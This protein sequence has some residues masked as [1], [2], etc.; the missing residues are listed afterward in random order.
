MVRNDTD[1]QEMCP[2]IN[3]GDDRCASR[4]TL[5]RLAEAFGHCVGDYRSCP[6]YYRLL[7][8]NPQTDPEDRLTPL[9]AHGQAV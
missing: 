6:T 3:A 5:S 8:E 7:H 9:T 4:F 1:M 2:F